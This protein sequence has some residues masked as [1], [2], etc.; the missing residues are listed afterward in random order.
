MCK[1][2]KPVQN[3]RIWEF[4]SEMVT[5]PWFKIH[6]DHVGPFPPSKKGNKNIKTLVEYSSK[7]AVLVSARNLAA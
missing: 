4:V 3:A 6:V 7:Y 5:R 2:S 1:L